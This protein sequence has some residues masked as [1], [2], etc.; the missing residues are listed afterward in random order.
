MTFTI[1]QDVIIITFL[2]LPH[3]IFKP[4]AV[5]ENEVVNGKPFKCLILDVK[6]VLSAEVAFKCLVPIFAMNIQQVDA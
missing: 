4:I 6:A 5:I 2:H 1:P 3:P